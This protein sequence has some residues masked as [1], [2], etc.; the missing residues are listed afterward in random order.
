LPDC[1]AVV[2]AR[3]GDQLDDEAA[4]V[5]DGGRSFILPD[6]GTEVVDREQVDQ[7]DETPTAVV[8]AIHPTTTASDF[9]IR[10]L[11][12]TVADVNPDWSDIA[13][14]VEV[15]FREALAKT[16]LDYGGKETPDPAECRRNGLVVYSYP[17]PRLMQSRRS[18]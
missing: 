18:S 4:I 6:V 2:T 13:P 7:G 15:V 9:V 12:A 11:D 14:V 8:V 17:A 10:G 1:P 16:T 3:S 5:T